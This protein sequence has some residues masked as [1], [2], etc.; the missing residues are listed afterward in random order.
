MEY[1][2]SKLSEECRVSA[3]EFLS[4]SG[5]HPLTLLYYL[6]RADYYSPCV[7]L[8]CQKWVNNYYKCP[9]V[10]TPHISTLYPRLLDS[11]RHQHRYEGTLIL[12]A[13]NLSILH[14]PNSESVHGLILESVRQ[15]SLSP[16]A[17]GEL[18]EEVHTFL[19][20]HI[21]SKHPL[22]GPITEL[23]MHL[24]ASLTKTASY[25]ELWHVASLSTLVQCATGS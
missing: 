4:P 18:V 11:F 19:K 15:G 3:W 9:P 16:G 24:V 21:N 25:E 2:C 13:Y 17:R 7:L 20:A 5:L 14:G 22:I 23:S 1:L 10:P 12:I 6:L 8:T